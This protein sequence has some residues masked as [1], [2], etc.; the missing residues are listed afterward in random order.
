MPFSTKSIR[1]H[2]RKRV[3]QRVKAGEPCCFCNE[4]IDLSVPWPDPWCFV[5]DHYVPTS[6]GGDDHGD[7]QLRPAHKQC[8][9]RRSNQPDGTVGRNSGVLG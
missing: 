8:N 1:D 9:E 7:D 4:P 3:A 2:A 5:V 6:H